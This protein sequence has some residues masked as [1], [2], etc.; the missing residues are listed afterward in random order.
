MFRKSNK[1]WGPVETPTNDDEG[2]PALYWVTLR[3]HHDVLTT[4]DHKSTENEEQR[5]TDCSVLGSGERIQP[6]V[7]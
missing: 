6:A 7:R 2:L 3:G 4:P 1:Y 5:W